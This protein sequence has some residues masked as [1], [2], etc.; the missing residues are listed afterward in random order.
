MPAT[1]FSQIIREYALQTVGLIL[2]V[3]TA[4]LVGLVTFGFSVEVEHGTIILIRIG[5]GTLDTPGAELMIR[6][7]IRTVITLFSSSFIFVCIM[8]S[9]TVYVEGLRHP[10]LGITL[11]TGVTRMS[12][13]GIR[14]LAC[15]AF[16]GGLLVITA[17]L[18]SIILYIKTGLMVLPQLFLG[19]IWLTAEAAV[20][21]ALCSLLGTVVEHGGGIA[22]AI[23]AYFFLLSPLL[24]VHFATQGW[25]PVTDWL[26]PSIAHMHSSAESLLMGHFPDSVHLLQALPFTL[27]AFSVASLRFSRKDLA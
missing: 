11:A 1:L 5:G 23:L 16:Q 19:A 10:L 20:L 6:E 8:Q 18:L 26:L 15:L 14:H 9:S 13:F 2:G 24:S 3:L 12:L 17:L 4:A 22:I 21:L 27:A 25:E 7:F